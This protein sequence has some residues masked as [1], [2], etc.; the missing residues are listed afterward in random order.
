MARPYTCH[1][2]GRFFI[3]N[4]STIV[5]IPAISRTSTLTLTEVFALTETFILAQT[6]VSAQILAPGLLEMYI[7]ENLQRTT[8]LALES[9]VQGQKH[10][11]L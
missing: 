5:S 3:D 10:G 6:S 11:Q 9:F 2:T 7:N 4:R 1:N 8:K